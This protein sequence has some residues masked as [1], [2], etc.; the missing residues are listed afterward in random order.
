MKIFLKVIVIIVLSCNVIADN[1]ISTKNIESTKHSIKEHQSQRNLFAVESLPV[2]KIEVSQPVNWYLILLPITTIVIVIVG[3]LIT[4][5][6]IIRKSEESIKTSKMEVL[7][8]NRQAWI[9]TLRDDISKFIGEVDS[10][11]KYILLY[12]QDALNEEKIVTKKDVILSANKMRELKSKIEL[13]INPNE[14][15]HVRLVQLLENVIQNLQKQEDNDQNINN[16]TALAQQILK[17][18]WER[19]KKGD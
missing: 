15:K 4:R 9:N 6:Q 13:L 16:L 7:S 19:V 12:H 2:I 11:K 5:L 1:N 8:K 17:E 3:F 14:E 18:E 10:V